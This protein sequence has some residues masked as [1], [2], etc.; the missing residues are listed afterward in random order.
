[1]FMLAFIR[2]SVVLCRDLTRV[3]TALLVSVVDLVELWSLLLCY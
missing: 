1:M 2:R 3:G